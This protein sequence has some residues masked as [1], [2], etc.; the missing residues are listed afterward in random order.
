M[1][2][3]RSPIFPTP[4][5]KILPADFLRNYRCPHYDICL[6]EA[7]DQDLYLDC[8]ICIYKNA[9]ISLDLSIVKYIV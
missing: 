9:H 8:G 4:A 1:Y 6:G 5:K 2:M 7:A 3:E